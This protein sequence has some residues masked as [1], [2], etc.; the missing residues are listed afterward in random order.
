M[1]EDYKFRK[2]ALFRLP[3]IPSD[4]NHFNSDLISYPCS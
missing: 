4:I 2:N 1:V 3:D